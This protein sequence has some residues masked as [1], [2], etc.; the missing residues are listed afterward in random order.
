MKKYDIAISFAGEDREVAERLALLI[1]TQ[2]L[3]V[4]Y[5]M[6]EQ[7]DLW[8]KDLYT[9][10]SKVY[11]DD[12]KYCLLLISKAYATKQW[13]THERKSAQARA[14]SENEEYI[15]PLR[16]DDS[17]VDGILPT[18]GYLDYRNV[19]EENII[20]SI[21]KK[22]HDYNMAHNIDYA[23]VRVEEVFERQ[24]IMAKGGPPFKDR[25]FVTSCPACGERQRLSE[26]ALSL[27][28]GDTV[29]TCKNGCQPILVV[30]RPGVEAWPG[31]GVR[32]GDY[33]VRNVRDVYVQSGYMSNKSVIPASTAALMKK[34]P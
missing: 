27:E 3:N 5:D 19:S 14:F 17:E 30:G 15:L 23:L 4:F 29:Y 13:T 9:H 10:L 31:R 26:A 25:D 20:E 6:Y 18:V 21:V 34:R 24:G 32:L 22:V 7:A 16:L 8:G 1:S 33:V 12:A 2:G 11:K 28:E